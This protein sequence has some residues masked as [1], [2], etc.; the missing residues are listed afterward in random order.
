MIWFLKTIST[1]LAEAYMYQM[2]LYMYIYDDLIY[3]WH[4][5]SLNMYLM[6]AKHI[7]VRY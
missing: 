7:F 4:G 5:I 3:F 2:W 6:F 1:E